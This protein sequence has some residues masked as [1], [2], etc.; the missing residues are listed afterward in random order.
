MSKELIFKNRHHAGQ[1]LA[2]KLTHFK[3]H[4]DT[5]VLGLP[6]GGI[7]VAFEVAKALNIPLEVL[8]VRKLGVPGQEELAMGAIASGGVKYLDDKL[9]QDLGITESDV[10]AVLE[11]E[12][13]ELL[14][15][16]KRFHGEKKHRS[17]TNKTVIIV[18]DGLA[19]GSTMKAALAAL[20]TRNPSKIVIAVTTAPTDTA[21]EFRDLVDEFICLSVPYFFMGVGGS[22]EDFSQTTDDEV[23][24]LLARETH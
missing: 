9:I 15:R 16:E 17:L 22:Y 12:T 21:R 10:T 11:R 6:R 4:P 7:P 2:T 5:I 24:S 1:V 3:N 18:D 23:Q 8:V 13:K 19:T 14:S 20:R